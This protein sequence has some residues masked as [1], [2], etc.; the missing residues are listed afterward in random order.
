MFKISGV[1]VLY[2]P[3]K[4]SIENIKTYI[5]SLDKLF[6]VD[7]SEVI[8]NEIV[9]E[10]NK[11]DKIEYICLNS[12]KGI[13]KALNIGAQKSIENSFQFLL[14]MD[15]DSNFFD[16]DLNKQIEFV[17]N[18]YSEDIGIYTLIHK[19]KKNNYNNIIENK[20]MEYIYTTMTS[21]N[22]INLKIFQKIGGFR[23][24]LFIDNVDHD[25]CFKLILNNYRILQNNEV[26]LEH[27]LGRMERIK[28]TNIWITNHAP[29][30]RY[31]ITRNSLWFIKEY[32]IKENY[33]IYGKEFEDFV[34][35]LKQNIYKSTIIVMLFEKKKIKKFFGIILGMWDF[36]NN[37]YG[38]YNHNYKL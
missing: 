18:N 17:K 8:N 37:K 7:N 2:N 27:E 38:R 35:L 22:I 19:I 36:I 28:N 32:G 24:E 9:N 10:L 29:I 33:K 26:F 23:E 4:E 15:Q 34:K 14:T 30:R 6:V 31:Y 1:V 3:C 25:Y 13:A 20:S 16:N 11:I 12:N 5:N 21:G